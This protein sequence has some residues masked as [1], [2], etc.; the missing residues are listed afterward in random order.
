MVS[1]KILVNDKEYTI[2]PLRLK[3][4]KQ[5]SEILSEAASSTTP[6]KGGIYANVERWSPLL[7][8]SLQTHNSELTMDFI[9]DMTLTEFNE[10]WTKVISISNIQLVS[11]GE[12]TPAPE[13][14]TGDS[15]TAESAPPP[16]PDTVQ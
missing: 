12:T 10:A 14:S 11:K 5:M 9:Q 8:S 15:S 4:L 1:A 3:H 2:G 16:G 13:T 7:L 6:L